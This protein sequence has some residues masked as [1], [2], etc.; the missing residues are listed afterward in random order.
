MIIPSVEFACLVTLAGSI[1]QSWYEL[2][3]WG[4]MLLS[5]LGG[6]ARTEV[7]LSQ[8]GTRALHAEST[9]VR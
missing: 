7:G 8:D 2:G 1:K 4:I 3:V 9:L 6:M 5:C